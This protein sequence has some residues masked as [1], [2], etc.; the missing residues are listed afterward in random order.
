MRGSVVLDRPRGTGREA[1]S[2]DISTSMRDKNTSR[3][4][5]RLRTNQ[6]VDRSVIEQDQIRPGAAWAQRESGNGSPPSREIKALSAGP[7]MALES[8]TTFPSAKAAQKSDFSVPMEPPI[9]GSGR[10]ESICRSNGAVHGTESAAS[11]TRS[12]A[13]SPSGTS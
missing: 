7:G 13:D 8:Q 9:T 5:V 4:L 12:V 3:Y 1:F 6:G 11:A 10:S 2:G